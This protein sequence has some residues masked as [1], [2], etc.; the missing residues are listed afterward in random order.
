MVLVLVFRGEKTMHILYSFQ[1]PGESLAVKRVLAV[2][3]A[4]QKLFPVVF[5]PLRWLFYTLPRLTV[6]SRYLSLENHLDIC[7]QKVTIG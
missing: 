1:M 4:Q 6:Q 5:L 3:S 7:L 2:T